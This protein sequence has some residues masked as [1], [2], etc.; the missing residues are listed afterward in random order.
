MID[1]IKM[2]LPPYLQDLGYCDI[3]S[4][5]KMNEVS[6]RAGDGNWHPYRVE[7]RGIFEYLACVE[8]ARQSINNLPKGME[9]IY[10]HCNVQAKYHTASLVFFSKATFDVIAEWLNNKYDLKAQFQN[11][12]LSKRSFQKELI[13]INANYSYFFKSHSAFLNKLSSYRTDWIHRIV[14]GAMIGGD[15]RPGDPDFTDNNIGVLIPLDSSINFHTTDSEA[16]KKAIENTKK[17][18]NGVYLQS[19]D[20]F[21]KNILDNTKSIIFDIIDLSLPLFD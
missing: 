17:N 8:Y 12:S 21:S 14:G 4:L 2:L 6:V 5:K 11:I 20:E 7:W 15:K 13:A 18:N 1:D 16:F 3:E 10:D 9:L 19:A